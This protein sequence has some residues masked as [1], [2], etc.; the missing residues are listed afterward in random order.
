MPKYRNRKR[1]EK[2]KR[3]LSLRSQLYQTKYMPKALKLVWKAA[4]G[5]TLLSTLLLIIRGILPAAT[6]YLTKEMV[7]AMADVVNSNG[8]IETLKGAIPFI[9]LMAA[10]ILV[11]EFI[12]DVQRYVNAVLADRTQDFMYN[13]IHEK[14]TSL[15]MQFYESTSY[16]DKLQRAA[17]EAVSRPLSLL[18]SLNNLLEST[19]T[20]VAII[21][22]L[23]T[24]SWWVP[25]MLLI[26]TL[27]A[28]IIAFRTTRNRQK[29]RLDNTIERRR[30]NYYKKM[31]SND[32]S[33]PELRIFN[34]G[35]HFK[36]A[37]SDLRRKLREESLTILRRGLWEKAGAS[38]LGLLTLALMLGWMG[39][40]AL[41]SV[42][43]LGEIVMFW[44]AMNKGRGL[45]R[46]LFLGLDTLYNDLIFLDD[47]F[48]F[49]ELEPQVVDPLKP[50]TVPSGLKKGIEVKDITF[51]YP[52]SDLVALKNYSLT[53]PTGKIV[54]IVGENGAG[55]STLTKLLC[56]F[57][58]PQEGIITWDGVDIRDMAQEDLRQRITILFQRPLSYFES[59]EDNI[60]FGDLRSQPSRADVVAAAKISNAHEFITKFPDDYDTVLGKQFGKAELSIGEW[61]RVALA[62]AFVRKADFLILDEPTSAMD[63]WAEGEWM[64]RFRDLVRDRTAL[65]ITHRFSTAMQA[66]IIHVMV[67]GSIIESGTH[68]DLVSTN[69][70]YANSWRQQMKKKN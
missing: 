31:L 6:V 58:D 35:Q 13:L 44:Q 14:T 2:L 39:W 20:L 67:N 46:N 12:G 32:K 28:L 16:F 17:S 68:T 33:M 5:W 3:K 18:N 53:V 54:A 60:R 47:L 7:N 41:Q 64:G 24:L 37:Y 66:D 29:W 38:I 23:F 36:K 42:L 55:K 50:I 61:Q 34:L 11:R 22:I 1:E 49:L 56:R 4:H 48:T 63:S 62:R 19:I 40:S 52:D 57:Y 51:C 25:L 21:G 15:D 27:P 9:A 65:I 26:G 43:D 70:H 59:V 10:T 8:N 69:G 30:L 45:V